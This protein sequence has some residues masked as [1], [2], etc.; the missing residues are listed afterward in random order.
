MF[1]KLRYWLS[2]IEN[3]QKG[4][5]YL[6][7]LLFA[8]GI[9]TLSQASI[10][11]G[12]ALVP[13]VVTKQILIGIV[14]GV[15]FLFLFPK[16]SKKFGNG[17]LYGY[18]VASIV[19]LLLILSPF[20]IEINGAT[21]WIL[22]FG[23][24]IQPTEFFKI[25]LVILMAYVI[26]KFKKTRKEIEGKTLSV[27]LFALLFLVIFFAWVQPDYG[28]LFVT[29]LTALAILYASEIPKKIFYTLIAIFSFGSIFLVLLIDY[30]NQRFS[31]IWKYYFDDL[32]ISEIRGEA[33][34]LISSIS[35]I[36]DGGLFGQEL[37]FSVQSIRN[38]PEVNTD[39]IFALVAQ[40]WG[41]LGASIMVVLFLLFIIF[42]FLLTANLRDRFYYLVGFGVSSLFAVEIVLNIIVALGLF[43]PT[44]IPLL[45]FSK[46]GSSLMA[47]IIGVGILL[48]ISNVSSNRVLK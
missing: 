41:F 16:I 11:E 31:T 18:T 44:G 1:L 17:F 15:L 5:I 48:F 30:I 25:G 9:L 23:T 39:L 20:A 28:F 29:V 14:V 45:F 34:Q 22:I 42:C 35:S 36:R 32:S 12:V 24:A 19:V 37:E 21:R 33:Y 4:L 7:I 8:F 40:Q 38:L 6:S 46:G 26:S 2:K 43:I 10:G 47:T 27:I 3:L 13:D